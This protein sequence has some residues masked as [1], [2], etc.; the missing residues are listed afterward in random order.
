MEIEPLS[1]NIG[2]RLTGI[3]LRQPLSAADRV[4]IDEAWAA[5]HLLSI[6]GQDLEPDHQVEFCTKFGAV[7]SE[8]QTGFRYVHISNKRDDGILKEGFYSYHIDFSFLDCPVDAI[9]LYGMKVPEAGTQT[10]FANNAAPLARMPRELVEMLRTLTVRNVADFS[11]PEHD[12]VRY[13]AGRAG[14]GAL[15]REHP[16]I[17]RHPQ[18]GIELLYCCEQHSERFLERSDE[19]S[20]EILDEINRYLYAPENVYRHEWREHDLV[21][22]DNLALQHGRPDVSLSDEE[23]TLRRVTVARKDPVKEL[24][25]QLNMAAVSELGTV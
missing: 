19:E 22:W 18:T 5:H 16:L 7:L 1:P 11:R 6:P 2:A 17:W 23:R 14:P 4:R 8:Q 13:R 15:A 10:Y 21:I 24:L 20:V 3:D 25:R 9:C 12:I